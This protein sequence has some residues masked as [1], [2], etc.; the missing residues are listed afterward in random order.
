[1]STPDTRNNEPDAYTALQNHFTQK[2]TDAIIKCAYFMS[3]CA[4]C[5]GTGGMFVC[6]VCLYL[7]LSACIYQNPMSK[8]HE[9]F[10]R[11]SY[12]WPWLSLLTIVQNGR[13]RRLASLASNPLVT[14][15]I[16]ELWTN[17]QCLHTFGTRMSWRVTLKVLDCLWTRSSVE[18][19][20]HRAA[21]S[22][23]RR[24]HVTS[25]RLCPAVTIVRRRYSSPT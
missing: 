25:A 5:S 3:S 20:T 9:I 4:F 10:F 16:L 12:L 17:G 2:N 11:A 21:S 14:V 7:C 22:L 23:R 1:M 24:R 13:L 19:R 6:I 18:C 8:L 15:L